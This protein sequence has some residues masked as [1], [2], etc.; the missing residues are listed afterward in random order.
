MRRAVN[1]LESWSGGGGVPGGLLIHSSVAACCARC[2]L[3]QSSSCRCCI[4]A[5]L[6]SSAVRVRAAVSIHEAIASLPGSKPAAAQL[7]ASLRRSIALCC[8]GVWHPA[9]GRITISVPEMTNMRRIRV[10]NVPALPR[11]LLS[12]V[13]GTRIRP[14]AIKKRTSVFRLFL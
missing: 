5:S 8:S 6:S 11:W 7:L 14:S 3:F 13:V 9:S 12:C 4:H 2:L 10:I 1:Q